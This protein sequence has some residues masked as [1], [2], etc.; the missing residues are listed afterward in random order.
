M[1]AQPGSTLLP[2]LRGGGR[3][4]GGEVGGGGGGGGGRISIVSQATMKMFLKN[5]E[6]GRFHTHCHIYN[7]P[8]N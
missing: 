5:E 2:Q 4:G 6:D 8:G 7:I 3:G 1:V